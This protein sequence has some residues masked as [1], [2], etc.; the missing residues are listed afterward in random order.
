MRGELGAFV[1]RLQSADSSGRDILGAFQS[2]KGM[3]ADADIAEE[4]ANM[5]AYQ[6]RQNAGA[7]IFAQ[8]NQQVGL[9]LSLMES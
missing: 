8:A 9:V 3:I 4:T 2:S 5:V 6:V 7:A 1:S